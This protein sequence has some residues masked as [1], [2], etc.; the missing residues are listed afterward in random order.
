MKASELPAEWWI[1]LGREAVEAGMI[2]LLITGGEPLIRD[3]FAQIYTELCKMGCVVSLNS[4]GYL[5][6]DKIKI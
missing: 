2:F 1:N 4:N 6:N 3:D 5:I